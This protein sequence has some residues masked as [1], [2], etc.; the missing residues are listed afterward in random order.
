MAQ[1]WIG[2]NAQLS[3][4]FSAANAKGFKLF[5]SFDYAGNGAWPQAEVISL[6]QEYGSNGAYYQYNN[7]PLVSTFEGPA[8]SGDWV[9]I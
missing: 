7:K 5:F 9:E 2:N 4:A 3:L 1:G 8:S 6:I